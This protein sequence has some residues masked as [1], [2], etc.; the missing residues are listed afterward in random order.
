ML[1]LT[2]GLVIEPSVQPSCGEA[3]PLQLRLLAGHSR[4][5]LYLI[6]QAPLVNTV[7]QAAC[8]GVKKRLLWQ[9]AGV[10][11]QGT[12]A[13]CCGASGTVSSTRSDSCEA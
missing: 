8:L 13:L 4:S 7:P 1:A 3:L 6:S 10:A 2:P 11:L 9:R 12:L 5:L